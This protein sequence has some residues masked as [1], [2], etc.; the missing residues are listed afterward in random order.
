MFNTDFILYCFRYRILA[1]DH[2]LLSFTDV[3]YGEWP[4]VL[5]TNPKDAQFISPKEPTNRIINSTHI[6]LLFTL[7]LYISYIK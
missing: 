1:V 4:V 6:R 3:K 7:L 5:I 2:D